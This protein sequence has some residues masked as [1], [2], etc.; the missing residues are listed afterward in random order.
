MKRGKIMNCEVLNGKRRGLVITF[1][2]VLSFFILWQFF[3]S[4]NSYLRLNP[5]IFWPIVAAFSFIVCFNKGIVLDKYTKLTILSFI[6]CIFRILLLYIFSSTFRPDSPRPS[7][8]PKTIKRCNRVFGK[9]LVAG[10][11]VICP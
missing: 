9:I 2:L 11:A 4:D 3:W 8:F 1:P 10:E 7:V 5:Y 6:T